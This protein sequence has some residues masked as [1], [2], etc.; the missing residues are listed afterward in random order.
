MKYRL[1]D[2]LACP[3]CKS[4]PLILYVFLEVKIGREK[5]PRIPTCELYCGLAKKFLKETKPDIINC[6]ECLTREIAEGLLFCQ[7]CNRWYPIIEEIPHMLPD[8]LRDEKEDLK[9]LEKYKET[10][11]Q[12]II[13]RGKP[14]SL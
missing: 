1:M 9:F 14:F 12:E 7:E 10:I 13:T 6:E 3:I 2:L 4:F 8:E 11:P 5:P